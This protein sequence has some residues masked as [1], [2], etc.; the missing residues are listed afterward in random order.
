MSIT[1][2]GR[3]L[4]VEAAAAEK[5]L[6]AAGKLELADQCLMV[7]EISET[8]L[9]KR[10]REVDTR[11]ANERYESATIAL[12]RERI[13]AWVEEL[14][15]LPPVTREAVR[16]VDGTPNEGYVIR[17]LEAY[18]ENTQCLWRTNSLSDIA[19]TMNRNCLERAILLRAAIAKLRA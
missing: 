6:R 2:D 17:I 5:Q 14:P 8:A 19:T 10:A 7:A 16:H 13:A 3:A 15:K 1:D 12:A 18:L 4:G 9:L 11:G